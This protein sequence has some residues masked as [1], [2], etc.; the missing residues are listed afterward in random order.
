MPLQVSKHYLKTLPYRLDD[1]PADWSLYRMSSPKSP[2]VSD[3]LGR[4]EILPQVP[5]IK[6]FAFDSDRQYRR[7]FSDH[8]TMTP[9]NTLKYSLDS[10]D[11]TLTAT[12][13][14]IIGGHF[15][16]HLAK[17][18][19]AIAFGENLANDVKFYFCIRT[20]M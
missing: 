6:C 13:A 1:F 11:L 14:L 3:R 18:A 4:I 15:M 12:C 10:G 2:S 9:L 5:P 20:L 17:P 19:F 7:V 8:V 16:G